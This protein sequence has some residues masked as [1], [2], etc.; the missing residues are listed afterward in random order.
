[1]TRAGAVTPARKAA[2]LATIFHESAF[3]ADALEHGTARYRGRGFIQLTG[4]SNYRAAG[5]ALGIDLVGEP[6]LARRPLVSAAVAAWYWAV[7]HNINLAADRLDMAAVNIAIGYE[8]TRPRDQ[9]RCGTFRR[10][11]TCGT[12][13]C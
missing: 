13:I 3:R 7:A 12:S 5:S 6:R 8:P 9:A 4:E 2:F 10:S 11:P 1:M